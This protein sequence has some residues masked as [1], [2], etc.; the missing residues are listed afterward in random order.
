MAEMREFKN[1][2]WKLSDLNLLKFKLSLL[3]N[4]SFKNFN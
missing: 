2:A 3:P 4:Y 1:N